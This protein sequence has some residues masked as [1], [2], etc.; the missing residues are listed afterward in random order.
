MLFP[1]RLS[2]LPPSSF[3]KLATLLDP[4]QPGMTPISLAVG[5]PNG[6]VPAF[7]SEAIARHAK[8]FGVYPP[9]NGSKEWRDAA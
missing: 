4:H 1:G 9:I 3:A 5:D 2:E 7:V 6:A 8:D